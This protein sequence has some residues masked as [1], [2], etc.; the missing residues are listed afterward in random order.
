M[1]CLR[2]RLPLGCQF[3]SGI[4][5]PFGS[6]L[7]SSLALIDPHRLVSSNPIYSTTNP[8]P[9]KMLHSLRA[10]SA[11]ATLDSLRTDRPT[12]EF[13]VFP[14]KERD[15]LFVSRLLFSGPGQA[16]HD[17]QRICGDCLCARFRSSH[18]AL[19]MGRIIRSPS[20]SA[21][22][23]FG[24]GAAIG[25]AGVKVLSEHL[26]CWDNSLMSKGCYL[27]KHHVQ[28]PGVPR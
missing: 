21:K 8:R 11:G 3:L 1:L 2:S 13:W 27:I 16:A 18:N 20:P 9:T 6:L 10:G 12:A 22:L 4:T 14:Y 26:F 28:S 15:S 17:A 7:Q 25:A 23:F 24:T 19:G 5:H